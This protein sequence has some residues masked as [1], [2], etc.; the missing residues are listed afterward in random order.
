M[1]SRFEIIRCLM[2]Y[3]ARE[4]YRAVQKSGPETIAPTQEHLLS[5]SPARV[6]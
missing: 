2:R 4:V 1:A 5:S 3:I 6:R